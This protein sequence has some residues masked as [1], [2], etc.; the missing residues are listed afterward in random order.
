MFRKIVFCVLTLLVCSHRFSYAEGLRDKKIL[1]VNSYHAGYPWSDGILQGI[2]SILKDTGVTWKTISMDTKRNAGEEFKVA[3]G[4]KVKQEADKFRPDLIIAADDNAAKYA[5]VPYFQNTAVPVVFCGINWDAAAY[6]FPCGNVT[7][8]LEVANIPQLLEI[9]QQYS[10]GD[11]LGIL[12]ADNLSN[13]KELENYKKKFG[14]QFEKEAFVENLEQWKEEYLAMQNAVDILIIAPPSF[15]ADSS[16]AEKKA[17]LDFIAENTSIPSGCTEDWITPYALVGFT[18][19]AEEQGSWAAQTA[20]DI[21]GGKP[22]TEIP[23][24]NSITGNLYLNLEL[25]DRI[26]ITFLPFQLKYA[27]IVDPDKQ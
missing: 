13:H 17:T 24:V 23:V 1:F 14:L 5:V 22:V 19:S 26:N 16:P 2:Q 10:M 8:M 4:L 11:R 7:G 12:G 18:K 9:L 6:G 3:A 25:A 21:L 20:L 27:T 15:L